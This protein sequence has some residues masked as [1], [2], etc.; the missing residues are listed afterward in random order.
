MRVSDVRLDLNEGAL[1]DT[2]LSLEVREE[3]LLPFEWS[4][5]RRPLREFLVPA[6]VLN[7]YVRLSA[8]TTLTRYPSDVETVIASSRLSRSSCP[9]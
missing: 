4:E 8:R 6:D 5:Q 3:V 1:G 7:R 2:L 9:A